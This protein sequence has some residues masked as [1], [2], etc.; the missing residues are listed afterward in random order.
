MFKFNVGD[1]VQHIEFDNMEGTV[2][3]NLLSQEVDE[4]M[5]LDEHW[6]EVEWDSWE[7][8]TGYEHQDSLILVK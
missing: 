5:D 3:R 4:D 7:D 2:V 1:R 8:D 6:C